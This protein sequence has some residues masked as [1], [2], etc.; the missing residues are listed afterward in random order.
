MYRSGGS[1][2]GGSL[3]GVS[4]STKD[5]ILL[6]EAAGYNIIIIETVG[7]GQSETLV[8]S[9]TDFFLYL[10]L[11][12]NGDELQFIKKGILELSDIII[13]NKADQHKERAKEMKFVLEN[14]IKFSKNKTRK[15]SVFTCSSLNN[16]NIN[17]IWN[18]IERLYKETKETGCFE[19]NRNTQNLFW[20]NKIIKEELK[21]LLYKDPRLKKMISNFKKSPPKNPRKTAL[22]II[23]K[24]IH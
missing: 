20:L 4:R 12:E 15:Q 10:T 24:L 9:M 7:V 13:I 6:C 3:G 23:K 21:S 19:N 22:D 1:P 17:N 11:I 14:I 8:Q 5:S 16:K 2:S 18:Q